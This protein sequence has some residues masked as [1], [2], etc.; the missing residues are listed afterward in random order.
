MFERDVPLAPF[1][2]LGL[3]GSADFFVAAKDDKAL[4]E[5]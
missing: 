5:A 2:T 3:G 1:T 4:V